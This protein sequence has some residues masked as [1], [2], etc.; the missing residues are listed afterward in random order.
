MS[1]KIT[2]HIMFDITYTGI[3]QRSKI[4]EGVNIENFIYQRNTQHNFDTV[5]Q[6]ISLRSQ[7]EILT[8]P[9]VNNI[10]L[11]DFEYFGFMYTDESVSVWSF[12]FQVQHSNVFDD[13]NSIFGYLYNDFNGIP[14]ILCGKE[15]QKL[16]NFIDI[17]PETKNIHFTLC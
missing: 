10:N 14:L 13:G 4:P 8:Y 17:Y 9:I 1:H 7:P 5:L 2:C 3:R 6:V 16:T 15:Y 11:N 12:D